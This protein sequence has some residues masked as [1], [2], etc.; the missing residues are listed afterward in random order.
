MSFCWRRLD[1]NHI[2]IMSNVALVLCVLF[3]FIRQVSLGSLGI[4]LTNIFTSVLMLAGIHWLCLWCQKS[5]ASPVPSAMF[6]G[7]WSCS[8]VHVGAHRIL[9]FNAVAY[10]LV[11]VALSLMATVNYNVCFHGNSERIATSNLDTQEESGFWQVLPVSKASSK[12][13]GPILCSSVAQ[14]ESLGYKRF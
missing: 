3:Q 8:I 14:I 9:W 11:P 6:T 10:T 12:I 13:K 7:H 4:S 1:A 2:E 5:V